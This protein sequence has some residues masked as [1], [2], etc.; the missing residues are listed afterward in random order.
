M[1]SWLKNGWVEIKNHGLVIRNSGMYLLAVGLN[2]GMSFLMLPLLTVFLDTSEYGI[3]SLAAIMIGFLKCLIGFNPSLYVIVNFYKNNRQELAALIS[4][5]LILTLVSSVILLLP[6]YLIVVRIWNFGGQW[7]LFTIVIFITAIL[8]VIEALVFTLIQMEKKGKTF[9]L[10]S[11]VSAV[12]Q[13]GWVLYFVLGLKWNWQGKLLGDLVAELAICLI[14]LGYLRR[15]YPQKGG[16]SW[17]TTKNIMDFSLPL[18]PHAISLWG[19]NFIDRFFLERIEGIESVGLYSAA[20]TLGLGLMLIYDAL[21][22]AWQP[23]FFEALEK[24]EPSM[25]V[26]IARFTWIYF[27]AAIV[28]FFCATVLA[29]WLKPFLLGKDFQSAIRFVPLIF[30]GYTFHGMYRV[31]AGHLYFK[32]RNRVLAAITVSAAML[33]IVLN[34]WLISQNGIMGAAQSTAITFGFMFLVTI[35]VVGWTKSVPLFNFVDRN[36][37]VRDVGE[38]RS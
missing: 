16:F 18:L 13:F 2:R 14:L 26:K 7:P 30:L 4:N 34:Y 32:N 19:M 35:F 3:I 20:Y 10:F 22:R 15:H 25:K 38:D 17:K 9:F 31:I 33:N 1:T 36:K 24:D 5:L 37:G 21:Q 11:L 29:Y 6:F 23:F 27:G 28:L 8:I 12:L